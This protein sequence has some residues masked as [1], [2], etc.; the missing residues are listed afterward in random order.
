MRDGIYRLRYQT[1]TLC[2]TAAVV[3]NDGEISGCDRFHFMFG[4]YRKRGNVLTGT[5]TFKRHTTRA[6]LPADVPEQFALVFEGVC[7]DTFGQFDVECP[8]IPQIRGCACFTWLTGFA[9]A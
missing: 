7:S 5:V 2:T 1:T 3:L 6:E 8:D 4:S 9:P